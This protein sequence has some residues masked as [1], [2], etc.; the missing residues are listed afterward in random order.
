MRAIAVIGLL[1]LASCAAP[2]AKPGAIDYL[3]Y[4]PNGVREQTAALNQEARLASVADACVKSRDFALTSAG[5][6]ADKKSAAY[7]NYASCMAPV[8]K[9][10]ETIVVK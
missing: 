1:A 5:D 9:P 4:G 8:T 3:V 6:N 10:A 7:S 2:G